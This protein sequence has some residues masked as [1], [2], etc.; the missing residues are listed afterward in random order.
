M[1][2]EQDRLTLQRLAT[3][4]VASCPDMRE[5][6]RELA[7]TLLTQRANSLA[8]PDTVYWHRFDSAQSSP[9]TFSGWAHYGTPRES[10]T[11]PQLI[12]H[13]FNARDQDNADL[14]DIQG[15]FY[16]ADRNAG[17]YDEHNEVR[18]LAEDVLDDL[19]Q[20]DLASRFQQRMTAFWDQHE[21]DFR[22]LAKARFLARAL[23]DRHSGTLD[24]DGF[25]LI[26]H[27]LAGVTEWPPTLAELRR[28]HRPDNGLQVRAL[29]IGGYQACDILH[30]VDPRGGEYLYLPGDAD[31]MQYLAD[32]QALHGWILG[33]TNMAANR[34]LFMA[35]FR[36]DSHVEQG[37]NAGLNH[38]LDLL[39]YGWGSD[40]SEALNQTDQAIEDDA[41]TWLTRSSRQRMAA[42]AHFAL[43]ANAD[44]RKQMWIGYL[45]AFGHLAG[46]LAAIDWPVALAAVGASLA[47]TGLNID[48]A[49]NGHTTAQR[50]A[51]ITGALLGGIDTL[52]NAAMLRGAGVAREVD[53]TGARMAEDTA[54]AVTE[55]PS[56][57][58]L[59]NDLEAFV[60]APLRPTEGTR[61]LAPFE[62]NVLL[63][64]QSPLSLEG[65][66]AHVYRI[67]G[68]FYLPMSEGAYQARYVAELKTW[69]VVDPQNPH[70]F[71]RNLPVRLGADGEWQ[72]L[73]AG[74]LQGGMKSLVQQLL[75]RRAPAA[76]GVRNT[77]YDVP[78][79]L[80]ADLLTAA[81]G[82]DRKVLQGYRFDLSGALN[83]PAFEAF[84]HLRQQLATDAQDFF[85]QV[86]LPARPSLPPLDP[87][88]PA[89]YA[90]RRLYEAAP[91][92]VLGEVHAATAGKKLLIDSMKILAREK[93][94][95]L[96]TEHLLTD[97]HQ[98]DLDTFS[99]T[100]SLSP[101]LESYLRVLDEGYGFAAHEP[102][103]F[104]QV[105]KAAQRNGLRIQAID[106]TASYRQSGMDN[107]SGKV[108]QEM[109][110]FY[111]HTVIRADQSARPG[112]WIALVGNSH[113]SSYKNVPGVAELEGAFSLRME[114][115]PVGKASGIV[116]DPGNEFVSA[117][118]QPAGRVQSDLRWQLETLP[119]GPA[120]AG[121]DRPGAFVIDNEQGR[122][123]IV[124][125]SK[126]G[127]LARTH[128]QQEGR[129]FFIE[130]PRWASVHERRFDTLAE[131][132]TALA[133]NGMKEATA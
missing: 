53:G 133:L 98:A 114:D 59:P 110:N 33:R 122:L 45:G 107:S 58:P 71:Y 42:D 97:Y 112:K 85:K 24:G 31:G 126:D 93:V 28:E 115:T 9:R 69:V 18:L 123:E 119:A 128:I 11:L 105:M 90:L 83:L 60:P 55:E 44:L 120:H 17:R 5:L 86:R 89:K 73:P 39:F 79:A 70:S 13:R 15:G 29:D 12:L 14:L 102:Y 56:P 30:L 8:E 22:S 132:K 111:A 47:D 61:S 125:R 116:P 65:P 27:A 35:H 99:Q 121:L 78:E 108:R 49:I 2:T 23:E 46:G 3:E 37:R 80:R 43:T 63:D 81:N 106:C 72:P 26:T 92:L 91:G 10:M 67:D 20:A 101:A 62:T 75:G 103:S 50:Q 21:T 82:G 64:G 40:H 118:G 36:L 51:G 7:A 88:M 1:N 129:Y 109:M 48:Q 94:R 68:A 32:R 76:T 77:L 104:T 84:D 52:F 34:A 38:L 96:Y 117:T 25:A 16:S 57:M 131:L 127:S 66:M 4:I 100:G 74:R 124:H 87:H 41:F 130:Q 54:P 19:W 113:A 95:T 6:A